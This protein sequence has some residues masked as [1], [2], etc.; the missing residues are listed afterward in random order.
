MTKQERNEA[1][2]L[3]PWFPAVEIP[4]GLTPRDLAEAVHL[5]HEWAD[6]DTPSSDEFEWIAI[7]LVLKVYRLL[8]S[9]ASSGSERS[10]GP[11]GG[12]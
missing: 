9:T 3:P 12:C 7:P 1:P 2:T 8:S 4:S 5:V 6:E 10:P 11:E